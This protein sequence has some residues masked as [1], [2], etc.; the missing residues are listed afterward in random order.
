MWVW[1]DDLNVVKEGA[2]HFI[3]SE[4]FLSGLQSGMLAQ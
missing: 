1:S 4:F 2:Y 3:L